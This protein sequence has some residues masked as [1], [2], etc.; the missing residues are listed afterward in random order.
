LD[1]IQQVY[2]FIRFPAVRSSISRGAPTTRIK[3][4]SP[5]RQ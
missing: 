4:V 3:A 5:I 1:L 2:I